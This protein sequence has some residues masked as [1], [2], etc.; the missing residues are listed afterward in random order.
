MTN[1]ATIKRSFVTL[2]DG[3]IHYAECGPPDG[4]VVL[5]LHQTPRSWAE[6]R[7][8]LPI[9]GQRYRAIA[10]DTIG[11]GDSVVPVWKGTI[12][13]WSAVAAEF[14]SS[15]GVQTAHVVG[16]HTG[17]VIAIELAAAR[18]DLVGKLVLSST[19]FT[20]QAFRDARVGKP[21]ID[22]VE[23]RADGTHLAALWQRRQDFYPDGRPDLLQA[24][25]LDALKVFDHVEYGHTAVALY[26]MEDRISLVQQSTLILRA[27]GDPFASPHAPELLARLSAARIVEVEKGMVPL[28]DQLPMEFAGEVLTFLDGAA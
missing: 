17:G 14:L 20:D 5:F 11:F 24:F 7:D 26:R 8:V 18:P 13:R 1:L 4:D 23:V 28:P 25:V 6:F 15:L 27:M 21:G 22:E 9:V 12:E 19:P 16:H 10:M 2:S 3:Q